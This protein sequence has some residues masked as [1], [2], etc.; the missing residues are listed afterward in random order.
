MPRVP[1]IQGPGKTGKGPEFEILFPAVKK[2]GILVLSRENELVTGKFDFTSFVSQIKFL[3]LKY[4]CCFFVY[5]HEIHKRSEF[6]PGSSGHVRSPFPISQSKGQNWQ[7]GTRHYFAH[8]HRGNRGN[9]TH[10]ETLKLDKFCKMHLPLLVSDINQYYNWL[11]HGLNLWYVKL[12]YKTDRWRW[13]KVPCY[14]PGNNRK[15]TT[16]PTIHLYPG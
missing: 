2:P 5:F 11:S 15:M 4:K 6:P 3:W 7:M 9:P 8:A 14:C 12:Q 1:N 10:M 16:G 13:N